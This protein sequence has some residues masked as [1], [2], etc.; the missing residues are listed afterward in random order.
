[1]PGCFPFGG[2]N[3]ES[4]HIFLF[5]IYYSIFP[6]VNYS[7]FFSFHWCSESLTSKHSAGADLSE[8]HCKINKLFQASCKKWVISQADTVKYLILIWMH[9]SAVFQTS[10]RDVWATLIQSSTG[11]YSNVTR[12]MRQ[13]GNTQKSQQSRVATFP[14]RILSICTYSVVNLYSM[15]LLKSLVGERERK[16][17]KIIEMCPRI[18]SFTRHSVDYHYSRTD[19]SIRLQQILTNQLGD[20]RATCSI[21]KIRGNSLI[22]LSLFHW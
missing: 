19:S 16:L 13:A 8:H 15:L 21:H 5:H 10:K 1:M 11:Y 7:I 18:Q 12:G 2:N 4:G 6:W 9:V 22:R 3:G 20:L 17:L 14:G